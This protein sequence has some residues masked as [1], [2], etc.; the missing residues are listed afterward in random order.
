MSYTTASE[1]IFT[2]KL[3]LLASSKTIHN[4]QEKYF[5]LLSAYLVQKISRGSKYYNYR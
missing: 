1:N 2:N 3:K 4:I 5:Y